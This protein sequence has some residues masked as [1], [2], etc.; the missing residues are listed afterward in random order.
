MEVL[1]IRTI[2]HHLLPFLLREMN[3]VRLFESGRKMGRQTMLFKIKWRYFTST[4]LS[5]EE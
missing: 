1:G 4:F 3:D 5:V 2:T